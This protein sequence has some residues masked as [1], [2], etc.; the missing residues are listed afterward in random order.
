MPLE[1]VSWWSSIASQAKP[2]EWGRGLELPLTAGAPEPRLQGYK[3]DPAE[4][5][6]ARG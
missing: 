5:P 4:V 1:Q 2:D 6:V 3:I